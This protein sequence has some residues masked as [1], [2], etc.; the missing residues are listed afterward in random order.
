MLSFAAQVAYALTSR[1][2]NVQKLEYAFHLYDVDD[3]NYLDK[4][5]VHL[6]LTS[7]IDLLGKS[8]FF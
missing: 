5:E 6:V 7:M 4:N 1:G 2:D 3:N 8:C